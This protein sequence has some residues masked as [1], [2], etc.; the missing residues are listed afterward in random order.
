MA[1]K[2]IRELEVKSYLSGFQLNLPTQNHCLEAR[3]ST[4]WMFPSLWAKS[5]ISALFIGTKQ[6]LS[7]VYSKVGNTL[8]HHPVLLIIS[9]YCQKFPLRFCQIFLLSQNDTFLWYCEITMIP[10]KRKYLTNNQ[11]RFLNALQW[12]YE[13]SSKRQWLFSF[14]SSLRS[15]TIQLFMVILMLI[16][17][18]CN[19]KAGYEMCL[20]NLYDKWMLQT[21]QKYNL[22]KNFE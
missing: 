12:R 16:Y 10:Q 15:Q 14:I 21:E 19:L 11:A 5:G 13:L 4:W 18:F 20:D 9:N 7:K 3:S 2:Q 22:N 17:I 6:A 1:G 8:L